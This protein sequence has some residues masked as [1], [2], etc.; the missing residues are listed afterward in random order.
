MR[1]TSNFADSTC[2]HP[3]T[4]H[5]HT[6]C[7][8]KRPTMMESSRALDTTCGVMLNVTV[9]PFH[10]RKVPSASSIVKY[11]FG[12]RS[13]TIFYMHGVVAL[14]WSAQETVQSPQRPCEALRTHF[15]AL[16]VTNFANVSTRVRTSR[17]VCQRPRTFIFSPNSLLPQCPIPPTALKLDELRTHTSGRDN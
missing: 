11:S 7:R 17:L 2:E 1:A 3:R 13:S 12:G 4:Q 10:L 6:Q 14:P 16:V 15:L 8:P 9:V 5:T